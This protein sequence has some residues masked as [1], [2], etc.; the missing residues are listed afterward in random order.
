MAK[1]IVN[2]VYTFDAT[3]EHIFEF[4]Y[5][6]NQPYKNRI[7]IINSS[8]NAT[9]LNEITET[10]KFIH[11]VSANKLTN[12]TSYTVQFSVIDEDGNESS[13]SDKVFF[14]CY[15]TP[16]ITFN[17]LSTVNQNNIN[18]A[19]YNA[20]VSYSQAQSRSLQEYKFMLYDATGSTL[21]RE[22]DV[23]YFST[24]E[25]ISYNFKSLE[26]DTLYHIRCIGTTVDDVDIDTGLVEIFV[27]YSVSNSY[28]TFYLKNNRLGGYIQANTNIVSIDGI[29]NGNYSISDGVLTVID[30]SVSYVNGFIVNGDE[31]LAVKVRN[32][33]NG[34]CIVK[35]T[36]GIDT[37]GIYHY[38]YETYDYFKLVVTNGLEK[39]ILYTDRITISSNEFVSIY[40]KR[41]DNLYSISAIQENS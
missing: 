25:S 37:V 14:T 7:V 28:S 12:G 3:T 19:S 29:P 6:G 41:H 30:G 9:V 4:T 8:T 39:Y 35:Q 5:S 34:A 16:T 32:C 10:M 18:A 31:T 23:T 20:T 26:N 2:N 22:S 1:P 15:T 21:L 24:G 40:V 11:T 27:S 13:L 36:N 17:D 38:K 33:D